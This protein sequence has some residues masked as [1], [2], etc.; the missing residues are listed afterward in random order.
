MNTKKIYNVVWFDDQYATLIGIQEQAHLN[1]IKLYGFSN[2]KDGIE[3]LEK[4][5]EK[6]DAA[7]VDG[8]FYKEPGQTGDT[9]SPH[10][11]FEVGKKIVELQPKKVLDWFIL[12]GQT[13]FTKDKH[14][15]AEAFK[16]NKVYDKNKDE[17]L[18]E[19]WKDIQEAADKQPLTQIRHKHQ[20]VFDVCT[21]N[22]IGEDASKYLMPIL[23]SMEHPHETFDD[24]QHFNG[25]RK[26][27]EHVFRASNK[28]GF[29]HDDCITKRGVNL[30]WSSLFMKGEDNK[31]MRDKKINKSKRHFSVL[32]GKMVDLLRDVTCSA[33]HTEQDGSY[34]EEDKENKAKTNYYEYKDQI[35]SNYLLYSLTFQTMDL[36]LWFKKYADDN[37]EVAKNK[38]E[39]NKVE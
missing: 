13:S 39:W 14:L 17:D 22:Y 38:L 10:A 25:L 31:N 29:L 21:K 9:T 4:N 15:F 28:F 11:L 26:I 30:T 6:Y 19:L 3:E 8:L 18:K 5:L 24:E 2:A 36:L 32:L 35:Q 23:Y 12:S 27:L 33:S 20:K 7:I 37:H 1:G 16:N 34:I